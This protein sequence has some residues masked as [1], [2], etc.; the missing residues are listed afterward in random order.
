M[1]DNHQ[2]EE[3][4]VQIKLKKL[5]NL[6]KSKKKKT[7]NEIDFLNRYRNN[8]RNIRDLYYRYQI[9]SAKTDICDRVIKIV[10]RAK[11]DNFFL[12]YMFKFAKSRG[13]FCAKMIFLCAQKQI[14]ESDIR[15]YYFYK[16]NESRDLEAYYNCS[17]FKK[18]IEAMFAEMYGRCTEKT[19]IE[20]YISYRNIYNSINY[21]SFGKNCAY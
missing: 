15:K 3:C 4:A 6:I 16:K 19:K 1:I 2:Q 18:R 10:K 9:Q 21:H 11:S 8:K 14:N 17:C 5:L 7:I 20:E 12:E 13:S